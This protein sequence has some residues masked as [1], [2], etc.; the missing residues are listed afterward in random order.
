MHTDR[1]KAG[2]RDTVTVSET[3]GDRERG[4]D[5]VENGRVCDWAPLSLHS[6]SEKLSKAEKR[7]ASLCSLHP[8]LVVW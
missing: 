4:E 8:F 6:P 3:L 7:V 2:L 5:P 1:E